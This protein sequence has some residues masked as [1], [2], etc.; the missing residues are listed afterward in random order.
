MR[1]GVACVDL[2]VCL[3]HSLCV[4]PEGLLLDESCHQILVGHLQYLSHGQRR[5]ILPKATWHS[6]GLGNEAG[7]GA[8]AMAWRCS[9]CAAAHARPVQRLG[10]RS[11]WSGRGR[12]PPPPRIVIMCDFVGGV[13]EA[14]M[15]LMR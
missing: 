8:L 9:A 5:R 11:L 4:Y 13:A 15:V 2:A 14:A 7:T 1:G 3:E 10:P 12:P 6:R